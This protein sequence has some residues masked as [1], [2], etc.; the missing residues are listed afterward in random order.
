M[1]SP[2]LIHQIARP[3]K[4]ILPES[5]WSPARPLCHWYFHPFPRPLAEQC[6]EGCVRP[7][8]QSHPMVHVSCN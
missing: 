5:V 6:T 1:N 7:H 4:K 2:T 8:W 3:I